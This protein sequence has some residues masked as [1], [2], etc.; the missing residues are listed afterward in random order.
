MHQCFDCG[1]EFT[2]ED[3]SQTYTPPVEH[4]PYCGGDAA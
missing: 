2:V 3:Q 4:C 1:K